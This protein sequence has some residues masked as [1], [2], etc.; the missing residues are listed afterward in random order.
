MTT[1]SVTAVLLDLPYVRYVVYTCGTQG[2]ADLECEWT[3]HDPRGVEEHGVDQAPRRVDQGILCKP[4]KKVTITSGRKGIVLCTALT[5]TKRAMTFRWFGGLTASKMCRVATC[6]PSSGRW[7]PPDQS[8][9]R[10]GAQVVSWQL[11]SRVAHLPL[12][13]DH[14]LVPQ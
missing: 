3:G 13:A 1:P 8:L 9:Q 4:C 6:L 10:Q 7:R 12:R 2:G 14:P 11:V 5:A